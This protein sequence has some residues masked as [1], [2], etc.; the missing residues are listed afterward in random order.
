M[1]QKM[2]AFLLICGFVGVA[3]AENLPQI[4]TSEVFYDA[5]QVDEQR[6]VEEEVAAQDFVG[7]ESEEGYEDYQITGRQ[8]V[9][10]WPFQKQ[11]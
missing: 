3:F 10:A 11:M 9:P 8:N 7:P 2:C 6:V 4:V 1:F 5:G